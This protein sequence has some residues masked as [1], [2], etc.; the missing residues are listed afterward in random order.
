M[1][2]ILLLSA[3]IISACQFSF[4]QVDSLKVIAAFKDSINAT[5]EYQRGTVQLKDGDGELLADLKVPQGF[6]YLDAKQS[7]YVIEELWG[8]PKSNSSLGMLFPENAGPMTDASY[9][10]NILFD[11]MGFV[12]DDDADDMDYD[13]LLS[14]MQKEASETNEERVKSGYERVE[15]VGW[16]SK[17]YYD[18]EKHILHWA[19]ELKFGESDDNTLNYNVRVLGR[20][21]VLIINAISSMSELQ[22]VNKNIGKVTDIVTFADGNKYSDF[23]PSVDK[24][25]AFTVGGLV[26]GK[27]L[28]KVG[29]FA[30][31][32]K[33]GKVIFLAIAGAGASIWKWFTGRKNEEDEPQ[34][35][36]P[37]ENS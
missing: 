6:K 35:K 19:K 34:L 15:L 36:L 10:F 28:A 2:K 20:K 27:V 18:K 26:A 13:E 23:N 29:F 11:P 7:V 17:P 1:K 8:N 32:A 12:E 37:E 9:A 21:G 33:F 16:A 30:I 31:I 24:V 4:G 22:E 14:D 5:M 25:A 3:L